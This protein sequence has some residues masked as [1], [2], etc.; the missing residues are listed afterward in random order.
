[1]FKNLFY[2]KINHFY[3]LMYQDKKQGAPFP[4][5]IQSYQKGQKKTNHF[6][7]HQTKSIRIISSS[8]NSN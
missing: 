8:F 1:M 4:C 3:A 2:Q 5:R 7:I 6:L